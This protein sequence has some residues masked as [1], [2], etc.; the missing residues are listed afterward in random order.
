[1]R[2]T[3][4]PS[5]LCVLM[6]WMKSLKHL[7][8]LTPW[9]FRGTFSGGWRRFQTKAAPMSKWTL[10]RLNASSA[11][12]HKHSS[13]PQANPNAHY[14]LCVRQKIAR[15]SATTKEWF[16]Q[17]TSPHA[18]TSHVKRIGNEY[19]SGTTN[20]LK[21]C[22]GTC[23]WPMTSFKTARLSP[24]SAHLTINA[25]KEQFTRRKKK[26]K[27]KRNLIPSSNS[28]TLSYTTSRGVWR[29]QKLSS[30]VVTMAS[31]RLICNRDST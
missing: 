15:T 14:T 19:S 7:R 1:M 25:L 28:L 23:S 18:S 24:K 21:R 4:I 11:N 12:C 10:E 27:K 2:R 16:W 3:W 6:E 20:R 13:S 17:K 22:Y 26:F 9:R 29:R 5:S 30:N 8:K 31:V